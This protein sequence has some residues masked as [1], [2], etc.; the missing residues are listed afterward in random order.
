MFTK[1]IYP[2]CCMVIHNLWCSFEKN[3]HSQYKHRW[4]NANYNDILPR[5]FHS[6]VSLHD[7]V[8]H[9][10]SMFSAHGNG[11]S[12]LEFFL[13]FSITTWFRAY[14]IIGLVLLWSLLP[15][16]GVQ[17]SWTSTWKKQG[18][19]YFC[20]HCLIST[21]QLLPHLDPRPPGGLQK[22]DE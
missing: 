2:E 8:H 5:S 19:I 16:L 20:E 10:C 1:K 21:S 7:L 22:P 4:F 15:L 6:F 18:N 9:G 13:F 11:K 3:M 12:A 17:C 14:T